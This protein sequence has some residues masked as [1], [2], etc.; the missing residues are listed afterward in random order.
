MVWL[1]EMK[2]G[3]FWFL[4][5]F[6]L[7]ILYSSFLLLNVRQSMSVDSA[8]RWIGL[9]FL[10][11]AFV[12]ANVCFTFSSEMCSMRS[13]SSCFSFLE[14]VCTPRRSPR[15]RAYRSLCSIV[16]PFFFFFSS[17]TQVSFVIIV[18]FV[19]RYV[20]M[21]IQYYLIGRIGIHWSE[22]YK[23]HRHFFSWPLDVF[24]CKIMWNKIAVDSIFFEMVYKLPFNALIITIM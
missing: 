9:F 23:S 1:I 22:H 11:D 5:F 18:M 21:L 12:C 2:E 24:L 16:S 17:S 15:E 8:R 19:I 14:C 6:S 13:S 20:F 10:V 4:Y 7:I 3:G